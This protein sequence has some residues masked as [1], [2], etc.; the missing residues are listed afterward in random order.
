V[1][2]LRWHASVDLGVGPT[3]RRAQ[4]RSA[5][6]DAADRGPADRANAP[7]NP[8]RGDSAHFADLAKL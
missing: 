1:R 5:V 8:N 6:F 4:P 2:W 7:G 3:R